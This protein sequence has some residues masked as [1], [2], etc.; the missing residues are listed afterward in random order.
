MLQPEY[1]VLSA[2]QLALLPPLADQ[3][4]LQVHPSWVGTGVGAGVGDAGDG[5]PPGALVGAGV[6]GLVVGNVVVA[7]VGGV[8]HSQGTQKR[9][10]SSPNNP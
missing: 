9:S 3:A 5:V 7:L 6:G 4:S 1:V 2:L 10:A 8:G